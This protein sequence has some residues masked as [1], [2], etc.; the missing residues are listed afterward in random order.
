M[1]VNVCVHVH[2]YTSA[3]VCACW[4]PHVCL[5]VCVCV[6]IYTCAYT[7]VCLWVYT[8]TCVY[9]CVSLCGY[10]CGSTCVL[11]TY[12]PTCVCVDTCIYIC[13]CFVGLYVHWC[14]YECVS[15][16]VP[17]STVRA[18]DFVCIYMCQYLCVYCICDCVYVGVYACESPLYVTMCMFMWTYLCLLYARLVLYCIH[19]YNTNIVALRQWGSWSIS[20]KADGP[21]V[22][23]STLPAIWKRPGTPEWGWAPDTCWLFTHL[24]KTEGGVENQL[25]L[26]S[27]PTLSH[28]QASWGCV[29]KGRPSA[30][31]AFQ[32]HSSSA[33]DDQWSP[34]ICPASSSLLGRSTAKMSGRQL[35]TGKGGGWGFVL[36]PP[37]L[38]GGVKQ[39]REPYVVD[40]PSPRVN[41]LS[42]LMPYPRIPCLQHEGTISKSPVGY[43]NHR[44]QSLWKL[45]AK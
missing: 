7:Y 42:C 14:V 30:S 38:G 19:T 4:C 33:D 24:W 29:A 27:I 6:Q 40:Q 18:C 39:N 45:S 9:L 11:R 2:G 12:V 15:M 34:K 23:A 32:A 31:A 35:R 28:I 21:C 41:C 10:V 25:P 3:C 22:P 36:P 43:K 13:I 37:L 26:H 1:T 5:H 20:Q 17:V 8:R 16:Y 44:R